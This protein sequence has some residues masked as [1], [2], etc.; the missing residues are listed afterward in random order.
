M[1]KREMHCSY[2]Q[3]QYP[4]DGGAAMKRHVRKYS[5]YI[6]GASPKAAHEDAVPSGAYAFMLVRACAPRASNPGARKTEP[7]IEIKGKKG[8]ETRKGT[9]RQAPIEPFIRLAHTHASS[10]P[11]SS[12]DLQCLERSIAMISLAD[13]GAT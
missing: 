3:Q 7:A 11:S 9:H 1:G 4:Y 6:A 8:S 12:S 2:T 5:T 10:L 13:E